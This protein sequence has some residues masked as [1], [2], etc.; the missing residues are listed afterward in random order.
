VLLLMKFP[1]MLAVLSFGAGVAFRDSADDP[2]L[3]SCQQHQ[4]RAVQFSTIVTNCLN[5]GWI[6][7]GESL[8][9]CRRKKS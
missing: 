3:S 4:E 5:Q 9:Q 2:K 1:L 8:Y 7:D 6:T